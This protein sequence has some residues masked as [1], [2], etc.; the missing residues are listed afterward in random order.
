MADF[1][2]IARPLLGGYSRRFGETALRERTDLAIVSIATPL[3]EDTTLATAIKTAWSCTMPTPTSS[4]TGDGKRLISTTADQMLAIFEHPRPD[5]AQV[6]KND[7]NGTCYTTDQTDIWVVL[8]LSGSGALKALERLCPVDLHPN[9]FAV[10]D[11]ARTVMEHMGALV[12]RTDDNTYLLMSASSSAK[13]FL[14]AVETS[15]V[16]VS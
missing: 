7:L 16:Y 5:A 8:E 4:A 11:T 12:C 6:V 15:L 13:S 3:G 14:H 9:T 1:S 10:G 2:L